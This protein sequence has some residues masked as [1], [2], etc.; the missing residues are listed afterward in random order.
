GYLKAFP[1]HGVRYHILNGGIEAHS[2]I[3]KMHTGE[4]HDDELRSMFS[5][6]LFDCAQIGQMG[7]Y[8]TNLTKEKL[9]AMI[10]SQ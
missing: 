8:S 4:I 3:E 9:H 7:I 10:S 2:L 6:T 1:F 5:L